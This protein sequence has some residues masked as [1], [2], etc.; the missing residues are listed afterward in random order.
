MINML[1]RSGRT[2]VAV[3]AID[4]AVTW[5]FKR[6]VEATSRRLEVG[7]VARFSSDADE[8]EVKICR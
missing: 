5:P 1:H 6:R 7:S 4:R 2:W 8:G 3:Y